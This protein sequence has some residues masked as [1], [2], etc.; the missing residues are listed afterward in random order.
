M[1]AADTNI[2]IGIWAGLVSHARWLWGRYEPFV[3]YLALGLAALIAIILPSRR[4]IVR[5]V[6]GV[7]VVLL[8][9]LYRK[10]QKDRGGV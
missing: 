1:L 10:S 8:L 7:I 6:W 9:A 4:M 5:T 2:T 3:I